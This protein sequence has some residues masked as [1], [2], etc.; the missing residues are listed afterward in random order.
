M[1]NFRGFL[2]GNRSG[3]MK[4]LLVVFGM[5]TSV[6]LFSQTTYYWVGGT[7]SADPSAA[8]VWSTSLGG[9]SAGTITPANTNIFIVDGS[10]ISNTAGLQTG[11]V[12]I[13]M[14]ANRVFGQFKLQNNA[15]VVLT[16]TSSGGRT[17][18]IGN[19]SSQIAGND[20]VISS[21]STL[22]LSTYT[23]ITMAG[24]STVDISGIFNINASRSFDISATSVVVT[25]AATTG[26]IKRV[27]SIIGSQTSVNGYTTTA[28]LIIN[29]TY[30]HALNGDVLNIATWGSQSTCL[31]SGVQANI[32][33]QLSQSFNNF[34]WN[35]AG[36][37]SDLALN[38]FK[39]ITINGNFKI[40]STGTSITN[41]WLKIY[42]SCGNTVSMTVNGDFEVSGYSKFV[43]NDGVSCSPIINTLNVLGSFTIGSNATFDSG[44][45]TSTTAVVFK[46]TSNQT[47]TN[48]GTITNTYIDWTVNSGATV[49][50][51]SD[52]PIATSRTATVTGTL[53]CGTAAAPKNVTGTGSFIL[54]NA[55]TA[56][57]RITNSTAGITSAVGTATGNVL[58]TTAR[59]FNTGAKYYYMG[60]AAQ[61]TGTGLPAS[62]HTL[63]I[64]L[65]TN[66]TLT[67][68]ASSRTLGA[69]GIVFLDYA[70]GSAP[71]T[72]GS[73]LAMNSGPVTV[74]TTTPLTAGT[75][76]LVANSATGVSGTLD[77]RFEQ[78][79]KRFE[80]VNQR[81]EDNLS[82][83]GYMIGLFG[84]MF[85]LTLVF[86]LWDR[87][88]MIKPFE[89]KVNEIDAE[90][91]KLKNNKNTQLKILS[92][93][94][95]L[96]K[97][98]PK[99]AD[100]L[101]SHKLL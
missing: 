101:K 66:T 80:Q 25:V 15:T 86:A 22:T 9:S 33:T 30:E 69:G 88:T 39:T 46:G 41:Y 44:T 60:N 19:A 72:V 76:I 37:T 79:D 53:I 31:I 82:Y 89:T 11:T 7:V 93:L 18:T 58:T 63:T 55:S 17:V 92:V 4:V 68:S 21:G 64:K 48:S 61:I 52:L 87:R 70:G 29:G 71:F 81:F 5:V 23:N 24:S 1:G 27:G 32:P 95:D 14:S 84:S 16:S 42:K 40:L 74:T 50:L 91:L 34:T 54:S 47:F 73:G 97:T 6:N 26:Y 12:S 59:T 98:D 8:N 96:S 2:G 43:L 99:L 77:K 94:R 78:V 10:D 67:A 45:A 90:L 75:Y 3:M 83:I 65:P 35:C 49:T 62:F 56:E 20:L 36:Q 28:S 57:L 38:A 85:A 100:I 51:A 13:N